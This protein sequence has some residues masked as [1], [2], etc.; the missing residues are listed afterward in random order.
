MAWFVVMSALVAVAI[1]GMAEA[2]VDGDNLGVFYG[3]AATTCLLAVIL[4]V[5]D[6]G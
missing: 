5:L 6:D 3:A 1:A 4:L 2:T